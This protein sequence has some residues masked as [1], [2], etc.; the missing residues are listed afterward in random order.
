M[1]F[2]IPLRS[3]MLKRGSRKSSSILTRRP[4]P[5]K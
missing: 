2:C 5:K 3:K 4:T 1:G